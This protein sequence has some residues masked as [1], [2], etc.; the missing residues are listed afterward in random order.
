[1]RLEYMSAYTD[2]DTRTRSLTTYT[3]AALDS[4]R[5]E[6]SEVERECQAFRRFRQRIQSLETD[7]PQIEQPS[8]GVQQGLSYAEP[9]VRNVIEPC[10]R[11]TVMA[12]DHYNDV[13]D[14]SF[15]TSISAEFGADVLLL[16]SEASSFSPAIKQ[17][18]L[19]AAKRC[20][21][22]RRVFIETLEDEYATL[23]DALSTVRG[24]QETVVGI[25][26]EELQGLLT[27]QLTSRYETLQSLTDECEEWLQRRQEQIHARRSERSSDE[28]GCT[29]LCS[30]LYETLEVAH[31]VL[32]TFIDVVEIIRRYEQQLL[33]ILA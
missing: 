30:Y 20:I 5:Q 1:M 14:D 29:D 26:D 22:S 23:T 24:I 11:E 12:V 31:P 9:S 16:I 8:V 25:D 2:D 27:T 10:Y 18:L 17:R 7:A 32:A 28:H 33:H 13:Y 4:V 19:H 21:D 3:D 15:K 6:R